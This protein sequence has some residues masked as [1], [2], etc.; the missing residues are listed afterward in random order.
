MTGWKQVER[1]STSNELQSFP[2]WHSRS[3]EGGSKTSCKGCK[4]I[5]NLNGQVNVWQHCSIQKLDSI[6]LSGSYLSGF[7][8]ISSS[9]LATDMW[10]FDSTKT[11]E[12][13]HFYTSLQTNHWRVQSH[14]YLKSTIWIYST[15]KCCRM[16]LVFFAM[17]NISPANPTVPTSSSNASHVRIQKRDA[18]QNELEKFPAKNRS[19][20]MQSDCRHTNIREDS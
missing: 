3:S 19:L 10:R 7:Y 12:P 2:K 17:V 5:Y 1:S 14:I 16:Y 18:N 20:C 8:L 6:F 11:S 9:I 4:S 13:Q 15:S